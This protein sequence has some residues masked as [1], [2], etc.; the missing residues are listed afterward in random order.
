M[1]IT[2]S[3]LLDLLGSFIPVDDA[4]GLIVQAEKKLSEGVADVVGKQIQSWRLSL[5]QQGIPHNS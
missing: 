5:D 3:P 4:A 2:R 1:K